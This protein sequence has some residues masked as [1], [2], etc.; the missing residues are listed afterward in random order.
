MAGFG[1]GG[2][3]STSSGVGQ[4]AE[5]EARQ[6]ED[7]Y[8]QQAEAIPTG[9]GAIPGIAQ[10]AA[11]ALG[12]VVQES[13]NLNSSDTLSKVLQEASQ[14]GLLSE[15]ESTLIGGQIG[16]PEGNEKARMM[17]GKTLPTRRADQKAIE[18]INSMKS[19][20]IL[21]IKNISDPAMRQEKINALVQDIQLEAAKSEDEATRTAI[22]KRVE[23]MFGIQ[24]GNDKT[25]ELA[26]RHKNRLAEIAAQIA[27]Y[28]TLDDSKFKNKEK[29]ATEIRQAGKSYEKAE[30][31]FTKIN[32]A[33]SSLTSL[34]TQFDEYIDENGEYDL[35]GFSKEYFG[36]IAQMA[37]KASTPEGET[38]E[39]K[40]ALKQQG[41]F[42]TFLNDYMRAMSG[43]AVTRTEA[44]RVLGAFGLQGYAADLAPGEGQEMPHDDFINKLITQ[45]YSPMSAETVINGLQSL[46]DVLR[47]KQRRAYDTYAPMIEGSKFYQ[48]K[49][50]D[51]TD[52]LAIPKFKQ[53]SSRYDGET[54]PN[55]D[56]S[57]KA[58]K[59]FLK[60]TKE[61]LIGYMQG[62]V[63]SDDSGK[64]DQPKRKPSDT[65]SDTSGG[66]T[67]AEK[68]ERKERIRQFRLGN[69]K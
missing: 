1:M 18:F 39:F 45:K 31:D 65:T 13:N 34:N 51:F 4:R 55:V 7:R 67:A 61:G 44:M 37:Q 35:P 62:M 20:K 40:K 52:R 59:N 43:A 57:V 6:K 3:V 58:T 69:K 33:G 28:K 22:M 17:L 12:K 56:T 36:N 27:G 10:A 15:T 54:I 25:S 49:F 29:M 5:S 2:S 60:D 24:G 48:P 30:K 32:D 46:G 41:Q 42:M 21:E 8:T 68:K 14:T 23:D 63:S 53:P 47:E 19:D 50:Q 66:E 26:L 11:P 16:T 64:I 38:P 9:M